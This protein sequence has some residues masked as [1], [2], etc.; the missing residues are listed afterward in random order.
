[1]KIGDLVRRHDNIAIVIGMTLFS[2]GH[3]RLSLKFLT[4]TPEMYYAISDGWEVIESSEL[5][6]ELL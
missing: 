6:K 2:A 4:E 5:L 3:F 1:M